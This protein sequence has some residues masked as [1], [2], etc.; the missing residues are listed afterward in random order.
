MH[1]RAGSGL[2]CTPWPYHL[3]EGKAGRWICVLKPVWVQTGRHTRP[4]PR[5]GLAQRRGR[6]I[7]WA[8]SAHIRWPDTCPIGLNSHLNTSFWVGFDR[9]KLLERLDRWPDE[10]F[11]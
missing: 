9:K 10:R 6:R 8:A 5:I 1:F 4:K 2:C 11:G 7:H 3:L